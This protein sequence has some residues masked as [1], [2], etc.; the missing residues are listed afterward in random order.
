MNEEAKHQ[1]T[2]CYCLLRESQK[3]R[4]ELDFSYQWELERILSQCGEEGEHLGWMAQYM[5][6]LWA[7]SVQPELSSLLL[8]KL[9][10]QLAIREPFEALTYPQ[11]IRSPVKTNYHK[12]NAETK[13]D[14]SY[15]LWTLY[16]EKE[17]TKKGIWILVCTPS[18]MGGT[19]LALHLWSQWLPWWPGV[20]IQLTQIPLYI[21]KFWVHSIWKLLQRA[22]FSLYIFYT[23]MWIHCP[24]TEGVFLFMK[25]LKKVNISNRSHLDIDN[26]FLNAGLRPSYILR[27]DYKDSWDEIRTLWSKLPPIKQ[28]SPE[29]LFTIVDQY[30]LTKLQVF[31]DKYNPK[32]NLSQKPKPFFIFDLDKTEFDNES[33]KELENFL[34]IMAKL[35]WPM[36]IIVKKRGDT[37][38]PIKAILKRK[39]TDTK[40]YHLN[41]TSENSNELLQVLR[42]RY[43]IDIN[44]MVLSE[45]ENVN[46]KKIVAE[47]TKSPRDV[48]LFIHLLQ[49]KFEQSGRKAISIEEALG[50]L[51]AL[52]SN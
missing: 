20:E 27:P 42:K 2:N 33:K 3:I 22:L 38:C 45:E 37:R 7:Q 26:L 43:N 28:D 36:L 10:E 1:K 48:L 31:Q 5:R 17:I 24:Y 30:I 47:S 34:Q 4:H 51:K 19:T 18:G 11:F 32:K 21:T 49:Q 6:E 41:W 13:G 25:L 40:V 29:R 35:R 50:L 52:G 39:N 15:D 46:I 12:E 9:D 23:P 14:D 44:A 8:E 16:E